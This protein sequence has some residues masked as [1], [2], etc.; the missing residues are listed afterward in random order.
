MGGTGRSAGRRPALPQSTAGAEKVRRRF[1]SIAR[2][3]RTNRAI[4]LELE[5]G[6]RRPNERFKKGAYELI[7]HYIANEF[8]HTFALVLS[9]LGRIPKTSIQPDDNPFFWGLAAI[10][11]DETIFSMNQLRRIAKAMHRAYEL[12]IPPDE[13]LAFLR[14]PNSKSL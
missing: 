13:I 10:C 8:H 9:E 1:T 4:R 11:G 5:R 12:E 6:S 7:A 3:L 2:Q 14:K